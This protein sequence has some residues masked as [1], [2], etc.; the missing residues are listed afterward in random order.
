MCFFPYNFF[1][2]GTD[3]CLLN[4]RGCHLQITK[5]T[6]DALSS[7][8]SEYK[9]CVLVFLGF[10]FDLFNSE[11]HQVLLGLPSLHCGLET[12]TQ[13][14]GSPYLF[15]ALGNHCSLLPFV[16]CLK[17]VCFIYFVHLLLL[18]WERLNPVTPSEV[19]ACIPICMHF[20]L[21]L[22]ITQKSP[23]LVTSE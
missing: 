23:L 14:L 4:M 17:N 18:L 7:Q 21:I 13:S 6:L 9:F 2:T 3:K 19:E 8:D 1:T 12:L 20:Y 11:V 16:A 10:Q 5:L 22:D 15:P